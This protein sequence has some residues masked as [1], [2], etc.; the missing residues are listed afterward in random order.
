MD[1][2]YSRGS[3]DRFCLFP[4]A[5]YLATLQC[6]CLFIYSFYIPNESDDLLVSSKFATLLISIITSQKDSDF[7]VAL[8]D[9]VACGFLSTGS[10]CTLAARELRFGLHCVTGP[11]FF[12]PLACM[13]VHIR[14]CT[15]AFRYNPLS[16]VLYPDT[17]FLPMRW[18]NY[19][20][21]RYSNMECM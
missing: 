11:I 18:T 14:R 3:W 2:V 19:V 21:K 16:I 13:L 4:R 7:G 9:D 20:N 17:V 15:T 5:K 12:T 8:R 10:N 6:I 1:F